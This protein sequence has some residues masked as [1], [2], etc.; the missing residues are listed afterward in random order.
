MVHCFSTLTLNVM[1]LLQCTSRK[2]KCAIQCHGASPMHKQKA[3]VRHADSS[4]LYTSRTQQTNCT[5][6]PTFMAPTHA[7]GGQ[8]AAWR[9][10]APELEDGMWMCRNELLTTTGPSAVIIVPSACT[11]DVH[12]HFR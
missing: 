10:G 7:I 11:I 12:A 8:D 2:L 4:Q 1:G 9:L 5:S 6:C 3:Q